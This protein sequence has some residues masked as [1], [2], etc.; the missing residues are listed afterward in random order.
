M[1][2]GPRRT[3]NL[4]TRLCQDLRDL[5]R[6]KGLVLY[7]KD[8]RRVFVS[9]LLSAGFS[10][11]WI[12]ASITCPA[13]HWSRHVSPVTGKSSSTLA[14]RLISAMRQMTVKPKPLLEGTMMGCALCSRQLITK[15]SSRALAAVGSIQP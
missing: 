1:G 6:D 15:V 12:E 13:G 4:E 9:G 5:K 8:E 14:P 3:Y 10:L 7:H 2:Y 11:S